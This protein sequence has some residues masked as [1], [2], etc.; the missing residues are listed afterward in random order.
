MFHQLIIYLRISGLAFCLTGGSASAFQQQSLFEAER[1]GTRSHIVEDQDPGL[2]ASSEPRANSQPG[3]NTDS[4]ADSSGEG[5]DSKPDADTANKT[6]VSAN[7]LEKQVASAHQPLFFNN[8]FSYLCDSS[9]CGWQLGD[10]LKKRCLPGARSFD[11]GGQYRARAHFERN[12][13]G[14]GLTGVDDD[15]LLHRTR[16]YGDFRLT[17]NIRVFAEMIHA[18][19]KTRIQFHEVLKLIVPTCLICL[20]MPDC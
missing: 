11:V 10:L 17:P 4:G 3:E 2:R 13:R 6:Q 19:S 18:E 1:L 5:T 16:L 20:S 9:Y 8:D 7:E 14:L 15:F 12:M